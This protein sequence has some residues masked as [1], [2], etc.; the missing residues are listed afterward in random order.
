MVNSPNS[1]CLQG[2]SEALRTCLGLILNILN[3]I[4]THN[5]TLGSGGIKNKITNKSK[6]A[7]PLRLT[8]I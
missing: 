2:I 8:Q 4:L 6:K 3:L 1:S 5:P 7:P